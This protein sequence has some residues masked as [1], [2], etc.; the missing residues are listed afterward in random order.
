MVK[1]KAGVSITGQLKG[2]E[3]AF[4][5][6]KLEKLTA[7]FKI[8]PLREQ[9]I[10][11]NFM[12]G[13]VMRDGDNCKELL[14]LI[15][16]KKM[17]EVYIAREK[18]IFYNPDYHG[19]RLDVYA[20]DTY[21]TVYDIEMQV[22]ADDTE[23][24]SRY[25]HSQMDVELLL[26]GKS[27]KELPESYVIFICN[28]DPLKKGKFVYNIRNKVEELLDYDY[29]DGV[30]T[31]F[32][33]TKGR[34]VDEIP[35]ALKNFLDFVRADLKNSENDYNDDFISKLQRSIAKIKNSR[36]KEAEYMTLEL[37]LQD[38][39]REGEEKGLKKGEYIG[40][41]RGR[42][43]IIR[44]LL[45]NGLDET[46]ISAMLSISPASIRKIAENADDVDISL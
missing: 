4:D 34:N 32:L 30:H 36:D 25:Y 23:L 15:L 10:K 28:Y 29:N 46:E 38:K 37:M 31:I 8:K 24:R 18:G 2:L 16:G 27:Y 12:F 33:S 26:K 42:A 39:Y 9:T 17:S 11:D 35:E 40:L 43:D 6:S 41:K 13:S 44:R 14:E 7:G 1:K 3:R 45:R 5:E 20:V 22:A 21:G 19:V